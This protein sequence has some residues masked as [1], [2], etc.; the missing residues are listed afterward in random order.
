[1]IFLYGVVAH[2]DVKEIEGF[3]TGENSIE[4]S[5]KHS[6]SYFGRSSPIPR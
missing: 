2:F 3:R 5:M 6:P 1:M 4:T